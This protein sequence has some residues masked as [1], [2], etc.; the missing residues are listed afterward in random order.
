MPLQSLAAGFVAVTVGTSS[1]VVLLLQASESAG[2]G[3]RGFESWLFATTLGSG[4]VGIA[5]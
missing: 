4:I 2:I 3:Q 5:L 1:T